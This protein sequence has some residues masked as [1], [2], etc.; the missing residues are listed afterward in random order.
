MEKYKLAEQDYNA[1]MKYKD[2]A[3]KYN[4]TLNTVKSW[5]KR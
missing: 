2:I 3:E 5:K 4:V 1:G